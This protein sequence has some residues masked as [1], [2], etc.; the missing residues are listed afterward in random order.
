ML[1]LAALSYERDYGHKIILL[2][3][4]VTTQQWSKKKSAEKML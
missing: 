1:G 2:N 4:C 3:V